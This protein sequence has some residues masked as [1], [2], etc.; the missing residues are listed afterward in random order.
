MKLLTP[1]STGELIDKLTILRIKMRMIDQEDKKKNIAAEMQE[2]LDVC[3]TG[4]VDL[5]HSLVAD[6]EAINEKLWKIE[7]DI[8]FKEHKKDFGP[9][10]IELARSVYISN[11]ERFRLKAKVNSHYG[12]ALHEVKSYEYL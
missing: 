12:S 11:D 8:R 3:R 10:F 2:L 7:D 9:E 5:E 4:S 1:I 6:L